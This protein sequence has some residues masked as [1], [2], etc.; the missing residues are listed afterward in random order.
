MAEVEP[1]VFSKKTYRVIH[2]SSLNR[3]RPTLKKKKVPHET[4]FRFR[5]GHET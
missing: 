1:L 2:D 4:I 3:V 5:S